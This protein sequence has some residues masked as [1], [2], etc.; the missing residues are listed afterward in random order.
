MGF[1]IYIY[2]YCLKCHLTIRQVSKNVAAAFVGVKNLHTANPWLQKTGM[3]LNLGCFCCGKD[4][5]LF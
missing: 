4:F 5:Y 1:L 3:S 2:I